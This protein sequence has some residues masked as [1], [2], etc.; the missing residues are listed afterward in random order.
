M[1][2]NVCSETEILNMHGE[3]VSTSFLN[4]VDLLKESKD[5]EVLINNEGVGDVMHCHT[6]G[7][8]YFLR[9]LRYKGRRVYTAHVIPDSAKGTFPAWKLLMPVFRWY[10]KKV[11][12]YADVCIAISPMVEKAIKELGV[13]TKIV[14]MNNPLLLNLWKRTPEMRKK[15]R[16][17]LGL[18]EDEFCVLGVG[19]L[20]NRKGC[21]DFIKIG[22][23]LTDIQFRWVGGRPFGIFTDGYHAINKGIEESTPNIKFPGMF[24]LSEMPSLYAAADMFIFPSYQENCPLAPIEAAASGM[25][26]IYRDIEEYKLLYKNEY[27]KAENNAEFADWI[28]KLKNNKEE[29]ARGLKVSEKLIS[30]FDKNEVRNELIEVYKTLMGKDLVPNKKDSP[31]LNPVWEK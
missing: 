17:I 13:K 5:I 7:P 18:K 3:G 23:Q 22:K 10:L 12:S 14:R 21:S 2:I 15:G 31:K 26:V 28:M 1:K 19:Q 8:Y 24:S 29:Y 30:Q 25:P 20:E 4:C 11:Y 16:E 9:G 6:Y 27:F